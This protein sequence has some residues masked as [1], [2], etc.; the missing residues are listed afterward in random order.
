MIHIFNTIISRCIHCCSAQLQT[1]K[2]W[3][4]EKKARALHNDASIHAIG[5][6]L[7]NMEVGTAFLPQ[8]CYSSKAKVR[9]DLRFT[10]VLHLGAGKE[11]NFHPHVF[12]QNKAISWCGPSSDIAIMI[13]FYWTYKWK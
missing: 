7:Y 13:L 10:S 12:Q 11:K 1:S 3:M 5:P 6:L 9:A 8:C 2:L 4:E